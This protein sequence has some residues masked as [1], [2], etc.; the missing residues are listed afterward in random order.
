MNQFWSCSDWVIHKERCL[1]TMLGTAFRNYTSV[2]EDGLNET[3]SK[4]QLGKPWERGRLVRIRRAGA[5]GT[6]ALPGVAQQRHNSAQ[7]P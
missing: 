6:P 1:T 2:F 3:L 4:R 5:G 7:S